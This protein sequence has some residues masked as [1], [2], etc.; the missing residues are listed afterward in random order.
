MQ[1]SVSPPSQIGSSPSWHTFVRLKSLFDWSLRH[2]ATNSGRT[3]SSTRAAALI[4]GNMARKSGFKLS[5]AS[6]FSLSSNSSASFGLPRLQPRRMNLLLRRR[7]SFD[8][9]AT[10]LRVRDLLSPAAVM[11]ASLFG[12]TVVR[13]WSD[14]SASPLAAKKG[15]QGEMTVN[16]IEITLLVCSQDAE[17]LPPDLCVGEAVQ[18]IRCKP[19]HPRAIWRQN[20]A[21]ANSPWF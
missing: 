3:V 9:C 8:E 5:A 15:S 14:C 2:R 13:P 16:S 1:S 21:S 4:S 11:T 10:C 12:S 19:L 6:N 20:G 18:T 7:N 17:R